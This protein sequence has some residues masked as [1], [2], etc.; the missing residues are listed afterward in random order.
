MR[1]KMALRQG[2]QHSRRS[3]E[4][5]VLL[6]KT[7]LSPITSLELI[8]LIEKINRSTSNIAWKFQNFKDA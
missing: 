8:N 2:L 5:K 6:E 7:I 4:E 1:K 3:K